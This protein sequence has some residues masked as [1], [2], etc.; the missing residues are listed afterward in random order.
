MVPLELEALRDPLRL[1]LGCGRRFIPGFVHV[2]VAEFAHI[3]YRRPIEDLAVFE[4]RS[5]DL[6]YCCHAFEYFDRSE[7]PKVLREWKRVLKTGGILRL[8]VPDFAALVEVYHRSGDIARILGPLYGR[9][10]VNASAPSIL[11]H[12][13]T[14]DFSSLRSTLEAAGFTSVRRYDWRTT[15]HN[16]VDDFSQAYFPHMDKEHGLLTSLNVEAQNGSIGI[17]QRAFAED[18]RKVI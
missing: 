10:E 9:I 17:R 16:D 12:R 13:T 3:D 6:I 15:S 7:A 11:Y 5:A 18:I 2:D 8:A 14:Y 1:H 4:D